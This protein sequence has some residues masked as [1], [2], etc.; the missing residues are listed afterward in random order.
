MHI[1]KIQKYIAVFVSCVLN[2]FQWGRGH[3]CYNYID[4]FKWIV[5]IQWQ[6]IKRSKYICMAEKFLKILHPSITPSDF[7]TLDPDFLYTH[8]YNTIII[9]DTIY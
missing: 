7:S 9:P 2:N 8:I 1:I 5:V 4:T 6:N 3:L